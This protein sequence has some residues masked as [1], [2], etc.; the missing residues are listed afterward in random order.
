MTDSSKPDR[1]Q[2]EET[3]AT[4]GVR[5]RRAPKYPV[6]LAIGGAV[7]AIATVAI[8]SAFPADPSI[9]LGPTIG[10]F[11]LFGVPFG[12]ALGAVLA[13]VLDR[14][15]GRRAS[16]LIAEHTVVDGPDEAPAEDVASQPA[17]RVEPGTTAG[18][19][20]AEPASPAE[21]TSPEPAAPAEPTN[22]AEPGQPAEPGERDN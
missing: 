22:P 15:S 21:P 13:L 8:T 5:I 18:P 17:A 14:V 4:A 20:A 3:T 16:T 12:V 6:F 19:A 2:P 1:E 10:Y 7:G 9:G 11:M